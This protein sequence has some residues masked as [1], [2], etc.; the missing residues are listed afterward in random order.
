MKW[1]FSA[2]ESQSKVL[3]VSVV[4]VAKAIDAVCGSEPT[5]ERLGKIGDTVAFIDP[6]ALSFSF[7]HL[8]YTLKQKRMMY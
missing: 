6:L 2:N 5:L 8:T 7:G 3:P 4:N 1:R